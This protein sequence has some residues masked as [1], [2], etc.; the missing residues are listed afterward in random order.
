[1]SNRRKSRRAKA[2]QFQRDPLVWRF[3]P[4]NPGQMR[5][6]QQAQ[7]EADQPRLALKPKET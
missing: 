2:G 7:E 1:M 5:R 4:A 6:V 3:G